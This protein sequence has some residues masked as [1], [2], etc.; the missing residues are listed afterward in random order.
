MRLDGEEHDARCQ[1][2]ILS[3]GS[4]RVRVWPDDEEEPGFE[5][6]LPIKF[7]YSWAKHLEAQCRRN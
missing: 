5:I 3:D 4:A 6:H 7:F 2:L 1:L